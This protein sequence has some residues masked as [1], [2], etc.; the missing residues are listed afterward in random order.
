MTQPLSRR[1]FLRGDYRN[2]RPVLRPPWALAERLFLVTCTRCGDCARACPADVL[3]IAHD[4]F[5]QVYFDRGGCSFCG[6]CVDACGAGALSRAVR[7]DARPL[8]WNL[9]AQIAVDCLAVQGI[10]CAVCREQCEAR[11]I[12]LD[13]LPGVIARPRVNI[14]ACTGCGACVRSC[15]AR[16]IY[17]TAFHSIFAHDPHPREE[18]PCT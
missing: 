16:A 3:R 6:A 12:M 7:G 17:M 14:R 10:E 1:Q 5:P 18:D 9:K 8:P 2:R 15:P 13:R 4:G 11:A